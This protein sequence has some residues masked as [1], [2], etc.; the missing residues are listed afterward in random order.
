MPS[1]DHC[2]LQ[3]YNPNN[4][5]S[6]VQVMKLLNLK[7][8]PGNVRRPKSDRISSSALCSRMTPIKVTSN[9]LH[10][11]VRENTLNLEVHS[12][13]GPQILYPNN[14]AKLLRC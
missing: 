4:F 8:L 10:C 12:I 9:L 7:I 6:A 2:F 1:T 5:W 11:F 13:S 3:F 14:T